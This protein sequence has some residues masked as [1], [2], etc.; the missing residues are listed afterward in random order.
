MYHCSLQHKVFVS[1]VCIYMCVCVQCMLHKQSIWLLRQTTES[2]LSDIMPMARWIQYLLDQTLRL[3]IESGFAFIKLRVLGKIFLIVRALRKASF[4]RLTKNCDAVT[5]F[6]R[7]PSSLISR[8]F[9]SVPQ[10][11]KNFS[12]QPA[13]LYL[14][15]G[16]RVLT[17]ASIREWRLFRSARPEVWRQFESGD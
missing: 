17:A 7:K 14:L 2:C 6:W 4:I 1:C 13:F 10:K 12:G 16:Y 3:L 11:M 5:W 15:T 9:A 8:R